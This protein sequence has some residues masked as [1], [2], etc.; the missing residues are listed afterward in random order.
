MR[1]TNNSNN[2]VYKHK[3]GS[4]ND[5]AYEKT[6][7]TAVADLKALQARRAE[8]ETKIASTKQ[9]ILSIRAILNKDTENAPVSGQERAS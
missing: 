2:K 3:T 9:M 4:P 7:A 8:I 5:E 6:L 1:H